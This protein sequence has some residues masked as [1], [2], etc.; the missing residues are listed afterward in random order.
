MK[1]QICPDTRI[2]GNLNRP[3]F[4][5]YIIHAKNE[6]R[7]QIYS[8]LRPMVTNRKGNSQVTVFAA[9]QSYS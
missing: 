1:S 7:I 5:E 6:Q 4:S 2:L 3:L 8:L 9:E